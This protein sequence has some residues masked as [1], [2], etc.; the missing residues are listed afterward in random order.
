[1][2]WRLLSALATLLLVGGVLCPSP[3]EAADAVGDYRSKASGNWGDT[4]SWER[5]NGSAWVDA[6][7][8]P[9][10][11][12]GVITI[13][14]GHTVAI[15]S[16]VSVDQVVVDAGGQV[17][18]AT[19]QTMTL[20]NGT[21]TD[22][23]VA[24]VLLNQGTFTRLTD[25]SWSVGAGGSYIH[26]T[27]TSVTDPLGFVSLDVQSTFIYR[28]SSTLN[29]SVS[30]SGRTYGNLS[31]E[32]TSGAWT[33][34]LAGA[35]TLTVNGDF[36][37]GSSVTFNANSSRFT[38]PITVKGNWT[39]NGTFN[40]DSGTGTVTLSGS[41]AQTIGGSSTTAFNSLTVNNTEATTGAG[42]G[43]NITVNG[44]LTIGAGARLTASS[45]TITVAGNWTNTGTFTAG[46]G[47]VT[48]NGSGTSTLS[49]SSTTTFYDLEISSDTTLDV[50]TNTL[51]DAT[52]SVRNYGR[53]KQ[54]QT[55]G[56]D[57]VAFLNLSSGKY[58]GVEV[59]PAGSTGMGSTTVTIYGEQTCPTP[60]SLG[61]TTIKR[62][63]DIAPATATAATVKFWYDATNELNSN[64]QGSE[65]AYYQEGGLWHEAT[66]TYTRASSSFN[67][68]QVSD[69][70]VFSRFALTSNTPSAS[71]LITL[72]RFA[73]APVVGGGIAV[74]WETASELGTAGFHLWRSERPDGGYA[75]ITP[76]LLPARGGPTQ[77]AAYTFTDRAALPGRTCYY[78]LEEVD[79]YGLSAFHGPTGPVIGLAQGPVFRAFLPVVGQSWQP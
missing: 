32:S 71:N 20:A 72:A 35:G 31:F 74:G 10:N 76:A 21:G 57:N 70:S 7:V 52:N 56:V 73:A 38:G 68:V 39:N 24:G 19:G 47:T 50:G 51:F 29:A 40:S 62:C 58:Y 11:A 8:S 48:F 3:A 63:F 16:S 13:R 69:V 5:Y 54:T 12:D 78:R 61:V 6:P 67:S 25:A 22:L 34:T 33:P 66:G 2:R 37:L 79:I 55:V 45:Y 43:N 77:S 60:P 46:T 17:T 23:T 30:L 42:L 41:V 18:I 14:N 64:T 49:G 44:T 36:T 9:T 59:D 1:M 65:K 26:N 15:A 75:R 4:S 28:G 53:L 27:T